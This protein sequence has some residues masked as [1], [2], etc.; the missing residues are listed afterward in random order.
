MAMMMDLSLIITILNTVIL[1]FLLIISY[2]NYMKIRA[3]FNLA[4]LLFITILLIQKIYTFYFYFVMVSHYA[5]LMGRFTIVIE[6]L[7][8][9]A[10]SVYLKIIFS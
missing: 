10:F 4:M 8:L 3:Q 5:D 6:L 2:K 9:I 1:T 7:Q